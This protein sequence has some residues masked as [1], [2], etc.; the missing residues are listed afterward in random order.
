[1][2]G[3]GL[4]W[5]GWHRILGEGSSRQLVYVTQISNDRH[6]T[7]G[8]PLY[9]HPIPWNSLGFIL[10]FLASLPKRRKKRKKKYQE[11]TGK[12][13]NEERAKLKPRLNHVGGSC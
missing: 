5:M 1:L 7:G 3:I 6:P 4:D 2:D 11:A 12:W 13:G 9:I 10:D 8:Y